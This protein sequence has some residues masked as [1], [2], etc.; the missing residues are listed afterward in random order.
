MRSVMPQLTKELTE[1]LGGQDV[2][3]ADSVILPVAGAASLPEVNLTT[4]TAVV[5]VPISIRS[6]T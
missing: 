2:P 4:E 5:G 3:N 1:Q 6:D